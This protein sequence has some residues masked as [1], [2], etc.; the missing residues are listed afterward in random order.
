[1]EQ[2][3]SSEGVFSWSRNYLFFRKPEAS[4]LHS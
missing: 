2:T 4:L 1:M 3:P